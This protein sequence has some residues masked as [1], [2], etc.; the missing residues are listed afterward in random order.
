MKRRIKTGMIGIIFSLT[1]LTAHGALSA[2]SPI[3][4]GSDPESG[5]ALDFGSVP[6]GSSEILDLNVTNETAQQ[7]DLIMT[8]SYNT[9]CVYAINC[10]PITHL[11]GGQT[12]NIQVTYEASDVGLCEGSLYIMYRGIECPDGTVV[13]T[14]T[15]EGVEKEEDLPEQENMVIDDTDTGD[16]DQSCIDRFVWEKICE[17]RKGARNHGQFVRCVSRHVNEFRRERPYSGRV[18]GALQ[19]WG[20]HSRF[21]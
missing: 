4:T 15:G 2:D 13:V 18:K 1:L 21:R 6:I 8:L 16:P 10:S 20:A 3:S 7:V 19:R 17:C 11:G 9:C 14:L 5:L 12:L